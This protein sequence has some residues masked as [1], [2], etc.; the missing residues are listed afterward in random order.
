MSVNEQF[1]VGAQTVVSLLQRTQIIPD[2]SFLTDH[3]AYASSNKTKIILI[4]TEILFLPGV[5]AS[6][7]YVRAL[8]L[9]CFYSHISTLTF[10][11]ALTAPVDSCAEIK[12]P[13]Q[14][15]NQIR[16]NLEEGAGKR[17]SECDYT[18][19]PLSS[20]SLSASPRTTT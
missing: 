19:I 2:V 9:G 1:F 17:C 6:H 16:Q 12:S 5:N 4:E 8:A 10:R 14:W 18:C 3:A 7:V 11:R 20:S 13:L 15:R